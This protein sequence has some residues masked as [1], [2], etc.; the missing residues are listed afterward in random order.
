MQNVSQG[1]SVQTSAVSSSESVTRKLSA[2]QF[3]VASAP[4]IVQ[5]TAQASDSP[6]KAV[7]NTEATVLVAPVTRNCAVYFK[8]LT[9]QSIP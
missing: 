7:T 8:S 4:R 5:R 9:P 6:N 2:T 1:T 3:P